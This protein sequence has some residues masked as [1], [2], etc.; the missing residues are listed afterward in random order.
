MKKTIKTISSMFLVFAL[1][2]FGFTSSMVQIA[3]AITT[4]TMAD[5]VTHN[6]A[7]DCWV[8]ISGNVYN[9]TSFISVHPGG[10]GPIIGLC[11]TD[12]TAALTAA[13]HGLSVVPTIASYMIGALSTSTTPVLTSV[14]I[15]AATSSVIVGG[16][17]Q[18]A[19]TP[20]DQNG[21]LFVGAT[22]TFSSGTPAVATVDSTSGLVTGVTVGTATITA[23]TVK[24]TTT[25]TGTTMI[26]VSS[27]TLLGALAAEDFGVVNYD[28]G[29]GILK[30]Y[31]AGFGLTDATFTGVQS[32]VVKLYAGSTLLQTNTATPK[33][34]ATITGVQISSPFDV[35]GTFNYATDGYWTNVRETQYGQSVGATRVVATVTLA[36][37]KVVTAENTTLTGDPTTIF[38]P[39]VVNGGDDQNE[40]EGTGNENNGG[41]TE[42]SGHHQTPILTSVSVTPATSSVIVAG[43]SQLTASPKDQNGAAFVGATTTFSSGT[44]AVATVDSTSGL[45]TGVTVG[46]AT[47]TATTISGS[48]TVTGTATV[49]VTATS[50]NGGENEH[51]GS[52]GGSHEGG[53]HNHSHGTQTGVGSDN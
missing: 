52:T 8:A 44:P 13:P 36:N 51:G 33:V 38:P 49:T 19:A 35:S 4:Y 53:N 12:G 11:G 6:T 43:T 15:A 37:G 9:L 22:T 20:L 26:T 27:T 48:V 45:V 29:L 17:S 39:V 1:S 41:E 28:T 30:G 23:T 21:N 24:G 3:H 34:G 50:S 32:V 47:I 5:V 25:V 7:A 42:G 18:L 31:T 46:T 2:M 10:A 16:T 14:T 40:N